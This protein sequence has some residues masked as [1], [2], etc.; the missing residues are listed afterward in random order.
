MS[1]RSLYSAYFV[2]HF[3]VK[4]LLMILTMTMMMVVVMMMS[5]VM[6]GR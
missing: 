6:K 3:C 1:W 5:V 4:Q 2:E